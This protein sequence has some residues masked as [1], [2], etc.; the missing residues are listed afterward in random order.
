VSPLITHVVEG[1]ST[2]QVV[3]PGE[4][5]TM[6]LVMGD[7]PSLVGAVNSIVALKEFALAVTVAV[8]FVGLEGTPSAVTASDGKDGAEFPTE[9]VAV[10]SKE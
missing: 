4:A 6:Y 7:P 1:A 2:V 5:V 3:P 9:F 10:T 8:T